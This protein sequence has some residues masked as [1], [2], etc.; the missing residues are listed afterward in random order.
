MIWAFVIN[1]SFFKMLKKQQIK[2]DYKL[3]LFL[4]SLRVTSGKSVNILEFLHSTRFWSFVHSEDSMK[5]VYGWR[6]SIQL[7]IWLQTT[8]KMQHELL[9]FESS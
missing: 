7:A 2:S 4:E 8:V 6:G 5:Q 3:M 9:N 1:S